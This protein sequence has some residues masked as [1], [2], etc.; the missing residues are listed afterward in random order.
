MDA[1][2]IFATGGASGAIGLIIYFAHR[3]FFSKHRVT[4]RCCGKEI[5]LEV[6][7]ST[8]RINNVNPLVDERCKESNDSSGCSGRQERRSQS[9]EGRDERRVQGGQSG[10]EDESSRGENKREEV[11]EGGVQEGQ[12]GASC[13]S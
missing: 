1:S 12:A 5:S 10:R 13:T 9:P 3:F 2:Q 7:A 6:D 8:P 4:S 11:S